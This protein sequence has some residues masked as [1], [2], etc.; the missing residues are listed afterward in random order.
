MGRK[1]YNKDLTGKRFGLLVV[2]GMSDKVKHTKS[3]DLH[4]WECECEC[5]TITYRTTSYLNCSKHSGC[6]VCMMK[7]RTKKM[8]EGAGFVEG[9]QLSKIKN[10]K[11]ESTRTRSGIRGVY[12][13]DGKWRARLYFQGKNYHLGMYNTVAEATDA[14]K[15]GEQEIYGKFLDELDSRKI[16][17]G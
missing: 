2:K 11:P 13:Q 14:R 4:L 7:R 5:G 3:C 10:I 17:H 8:N 6:P 1:P 9:T 12:Y 15:R 16:K